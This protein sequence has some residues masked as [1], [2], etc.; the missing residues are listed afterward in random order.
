[1]DI[2]LSVPYCDLGRSTGE[3]GMTKRQ[4]SWAVWAISI[5]LAPVGAWAQVTG[6]ITGRVVDSATQSPIP[7]AQ[8]H[9]SGT[10]LG[11][12][13]GADGR[14]RLTNVPVGTQRVS[15]LRIGYRG[16]TTEVTV[17][18]G[19]PVSLELALVATV[20]K[21]DEQVVTATGAT[22]RKR[23]DGSN[24]G[25]LA[26]DSVPLGAVSTLGDVVSGRVPGVSVTLGSGVAGVGSRI[27]IRGSNSVSLSNDPLLVI[28][29]VRADNSSAS[30]PADIGT[31]EGSPSR[32]NDLNPDDID[33]IQV[34]KGPA[35]TALYGTA[36]AN[37]V[38]QIRTK[39]GRQGKARF[40]AYGE[41]GTI[42]QV[43]TFPA[44]FAQIGTLSGGGETSNCNIVFQGAGL[45]TPKPDSLV[46]FN[47][48]QRYSPFRVGSV[49]NY[50]LSVAG[51]AGASTTYYLSGAYDRQDGVYVNNVRRNVAA[52]ANL[53]AVVRDNLDLGVSAGYVDGGL[54][55]PQNGDQGTSVILGGLQGSAFNDPIKHGYA[56][57]P[58]H[59]VEQFQT[60][61]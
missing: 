37:G 60:L 42:H 34:I 38:I 26:V 58:I 15:V 40:N 47:P 33:D 20:I 4:L 23:E 14:F 9:V 16:A 36:A 11:A 59:Q 30:E 43:V 61:Q 50:G 51:G 2:S 8:V 12:L 1:M 35:A 21:L 27:R 18:A 53:H 22:E 57:Y 44:N 32:L 39:Q 49:A 29:G 46:S 25:T 48:L 17:V 28:D 41:Q 31:G 10:A 5:V 45:C 3:S 55:R 13:T 56:Y 19:P 24:I 52:R 6:E 54:T 7:V